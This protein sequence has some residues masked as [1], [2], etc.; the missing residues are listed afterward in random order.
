MVVSLSILT[1]GDFF[2]KNLDKIIENSKIKFIMFTFICYFLG[3]LLVYMYLGAV[4]ADEDEQVLYRNHR[5]WQAL[6]L[7]LFFL[8]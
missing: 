6:I 5:R 4:E 7:N 1:D 2:R 3:S 8:I